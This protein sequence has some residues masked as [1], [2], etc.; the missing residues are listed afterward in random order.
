MMMT[1]LKA[2]GVAASLTFIL[3]AMMPSGSVFVGGF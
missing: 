3:L 1:T 2:L